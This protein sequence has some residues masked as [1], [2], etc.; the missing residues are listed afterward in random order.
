MLPETILERLVLDLWSLEWEPEGVGVDLAAST[1]ERRVKFLM[2]LDR[3]SADLN[4]WVL[5]QFGQVRMPVDGLYINFK[6]C[7][8]YEWPQFNILKVKWE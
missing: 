2:S 6:H 1:R 7:S 5:K 8:Q 4:G 3:S